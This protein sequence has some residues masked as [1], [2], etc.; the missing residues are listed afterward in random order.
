MF[1]RSRSF[2]FLVVS[3]AVL[4]L[5]P[6]FITDTFFLFV[7]TLIFIFSIYAASWNFLANSGQGSLGHAAF[8]GIGGFSSAIIGSRISN[9]IIGAFGANAMPIWS[10][11]FADSGFSSSY[12]RLDFCRN[13]L[14]DWF[15][16]CTIKSMVFGYG[17][18]WFFSDSF[19]FVKPV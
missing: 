8:L 16:L 10:F 15:G 12:R 4:A 5:I 9:A 18:F 11:I 19:Y 13:R 7:F 17:N 14:A 3:F 1:L 6:I 2:L